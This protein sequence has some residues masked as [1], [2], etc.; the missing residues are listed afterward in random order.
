M[1][2]GLA[3][4]AAEPGGCGKRLS[5]DARLRTELEL[6]DRWGIPH[7]QFLGGDGS[8]TELDRAKA[9]AWHQWQRVVCGECRTR[10]AEWDPQQGGDRH[11][12][13]PDTIRCPGC[14][15]IEQERDQV[16]ND[17]SG[18]GVKIQLLPRGV[19]HELHRN[20]T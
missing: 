19:Y 12:Y 4:P 18:Y 7:S 5:V 1:G 20:D 10:L 3:G 15:L 11:A 8:W 13:I 2:S 6:C 14:E 16:P 9:L 17:R